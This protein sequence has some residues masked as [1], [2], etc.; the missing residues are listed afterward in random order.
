MLVAQSLHHVM[1]S[2]RLRACG[3]RLSEADILL[4]QAGPRPIASSPA[5][6]PMAMISRPKLAS[7]LCG[8]PP[9]V[10]LSLF[11]LRHDKFVFL[12]VKPSC[13]NSDWTLLLKRTLVRFLIREILG[14]HCRPCYRARFE[15]GLAIRKSGQNPNDLVVL[16]MW[17]HASVSQNPTEV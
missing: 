13:T 14:P 2:I 10:A 7:W 11:G 17:F 4:R 16:E 6:R 1:S 8:R 15:F 5:A 3:I 12:F 9:T